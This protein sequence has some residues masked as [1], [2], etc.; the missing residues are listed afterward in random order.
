[1]RKEVIVTLVAL[2]MAASGVTGYFIGAAN[3]RMTTTT[4]TSASM[5][6]KATDYQLGISLSLSANSSIL[7]GENETIII[8]LTNELPRPNNATFTGPPTLPHGPTF[9]E[10]SWQNFVLPVP[11]SCGNTPYGYIPYYV[12][13]YNQSGIPMQLN[14]AAPAIL[15]CISSI[16][17]NQHLFSPSQVVTESI[18]VGGFWKSPNANEPWLNAAHSRFSPGTYTVVAFD[19]WNQLTEVNFTVIA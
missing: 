10:V 3:P 6:S 2:L 17:S 9:S 16:K 15:N 19:P 14:D 1:M 12:V 13:I 18:S 5:S 11:P 8:S 7:G 4:T